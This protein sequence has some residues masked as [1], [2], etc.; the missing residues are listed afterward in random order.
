MVV[1]LQV[2]ES[3]ELDTPAADGLHH[4]DTP[5]R[6]IDIVEK[7]PHDGTIRSFSIGNWVNGKSNR[8]CKIR[9]DLTWTRAYQDCWI[10]VDGYEKGR[11]EFEEKI[12]RLR[13]IIGYDLDGLEQIS[14][15]LDRKRAA[16]IS[17]CAP[18]PHVPLR[19]IRNPD[20]SIGNI[21]HPTEDL[22]LYP[23]SADNNKTA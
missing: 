1:V 16:T 9:I 20:H 21:G 4:S 10:V 19:F 22:W 11:S 17:E 6:V 3:W 13:Q 2:S 7:G 5:A 8:Y 15:N 14:Y 18:M 23:L 12:A